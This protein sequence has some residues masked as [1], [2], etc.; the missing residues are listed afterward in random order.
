MSDDAPVE[1]EGD[2]Y[3]HVQ[4]PFKG[5]TPEEITFT[6]DGVRYAFSDY[7]GKATQSRIYPE[8]LAYDECEVVTE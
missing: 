4:Q 2:G 7:Q 5:V 6:H 3:F 1:R 8:V